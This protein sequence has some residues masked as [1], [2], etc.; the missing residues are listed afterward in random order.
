MQIP[1]LNGIF[2]DANSDFRSS[3]PRNMFAVPKENG[4]S[5][6]YLRPSDGIVEFATGPGTDRGGINWKGSQY[7]VM[8]SQLVFVAEDGTISTIGNVGNNG[9][10]VTFDYSFDRLGIA[11]SGNLFYFDGSTLSQVTD[12]DLGKV[13]DFIWVDGYF[14]TTDGVNLIVTDL[15][16]PFS[17][18]VLKYG[19]AEADPDPVKGLLKIRNE[20]YAVGR[21]TIEVFDNVGGN[22][23]PFQRIEGAQIMG[24]AVG[25]FAFCA[26]KMQNIRGVA[27]LGGER[28]EPC[29]VWFGVNGGS[30]K[31]STREIDTILQE[32]SEDEL[33]LSVLES[34]VDKNHSMLYLHL[35]NQC[36]VYD[37][38]ASV[39]LQEPVWTIQTSSL[40]GLGQYRAKYLVWCYNK[41][42]VGDPTT[43]K[44]GYFVDNISHHYSAVNGWDF[45]TTIIYNQS[46]GALFHELELV[47]LT[48]NVELGKKPTIWTSYSLDG[49]TWSQERGRTAGIQGQ[50]NMRLNWLQQGSMEHWRIQ[51]FRG[52]S[53]MH[54]SFARLEARIEPLSV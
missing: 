24:G 26:F 15:D 4:I 11:S 20:P 40:V 9:L 48:G 3:Y 5:K 16:N 50:R 52:T 18:N 32:Y 2:A 54:A 22:F 8:G 30:T 34:R 7:R 39:I 53:E 41:W 1:I 38:N 6:G 31:I 49:V 13:V 45:G 43:S 37:S 28:N 29:A 10:P 27:Y 17:V 25:T 35:P 46:K 12:A 51:R 42:F 23:F 21:Y 33:A 36:L 19:S 47:A 14:M 44:L